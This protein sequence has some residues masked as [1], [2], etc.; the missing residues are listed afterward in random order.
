MDNSYLE[1]PKEDKEVLSED[2]VNILELFRLLSAEN[3]V[4]ARQL[5]KQENIF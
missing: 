1:N 2:V 5:L 4:K 3:K